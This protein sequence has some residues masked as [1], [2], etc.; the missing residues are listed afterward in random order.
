MERERKDYIS[1]PL[2][3]KIW[4]GLSLSFTQNISKLIEAALPTTFS[5]MF[6]LVPSPF[7]CLLA[8]F[9]PER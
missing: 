9:L 5:Y 7:A 3:S 4:V 1:H 2:L 6:L 8:I